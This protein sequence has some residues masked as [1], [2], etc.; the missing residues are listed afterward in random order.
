MERDREM[1]ENGEFRRR[2][3]SD[4]EMFDGVDGFG[5]ESES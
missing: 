5:R 1:G 3:K 2:E 4:G